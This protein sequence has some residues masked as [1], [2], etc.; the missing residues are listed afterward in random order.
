MAVKGSAVACIAVGSILI[1]SGLKG[2]SIISVVGDI[3]AGK[4]PVSA[5]LY[6]LTS[7]ISTTPSGTTVTGP[8][9]SGVSTFEGKQVAAWIVPIL[10]CAKSNGWSG[11]V[12]SGYRSVADQQRVC[13]TGVQPCAAPGTSHHQGTTYPDGAV[14]VSNAAQLSA[15]LSSGKCDGKG[16]VWAGAKDPVHFSIPRAGGY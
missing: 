11:T 6:A 10:Q 3:I 1:W 13:A 14:D 16:L 5:S 9:P 15:I 12:N 8:M 7:D 2:S 4:Q